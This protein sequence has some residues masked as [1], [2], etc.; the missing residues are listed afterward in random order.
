MYQI[1]GT[2]HDMLDGGT[3]LIIVRPLGRVSWSQSIRVEM[4]GGSGGRRVS[5]LRNVFIFS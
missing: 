4:G 3:H 5:K 2:R 1:R